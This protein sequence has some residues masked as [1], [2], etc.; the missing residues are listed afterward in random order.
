[1][2]KTFVKA[3]AMLLTLVIA[4]GAMPMVASAEEVTAVPAA[5]CPHTYYFDGHTVK[6]TQC[7]DSNYHRRQEVDTHQCA[8]CGYYKEEIV[9]TT[10]EQHIVENWTLW[11][12]NDN[13]AVYRGEC[14][15]CGQQFL[16]AM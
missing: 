5:V 2:K 7:G 1:M 14:K 10:Y 15:Y 4:F 16:L 9:S 13:V 3:V 12:Y 11:G 6:Y 8:S